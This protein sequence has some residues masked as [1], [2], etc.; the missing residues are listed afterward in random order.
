MSEPPLWLFGDQLGRHVWDTE[1]FAGREIVMVE[2][3]GAL[4]RKPFH[5]QKLHLMLSGMRHLADELGD[6]VTYLRTRT[7]REALE[8]FGRPVVVHQ[9]TSFP[10]SDMVQRFVKEGLVTEV[11]PN[12]S[13]ALSQPEFD[14]WAG[15]RETF[16]MEDFYRT[17]RRRFDVLM[18][19]DE[20]VGAKWNLDADNREPPPKGQRSL[21]VPGPWQPTEDAIDEQVRADLDEAG[22]PTVGVD[23]PR[24]FAVTHDEAQA[25]LAHFVEYRLDAFGPYEDAVMEQDWAMAHSL[26]SVPFNYGVLHPLD[27]VHAAE[28]AYRDGNASLASVEGFVRQVLGWREYVWQLYWRFG[29]E[30]TRR[31]ALGSHTSLPDW[32]TSLDADAVTAKCLGGA[33]EGVRDRGWTHHIPRLMILGNHAAQRGY[34]PAELN[35]WFATAFVDGFEW[36]MPVNVIGMS[37]HADGGAMATK[38]YSAGGAYLNRMTDHCRGCA[39]DP[40]V[41]VGEKACPFTA[42]YW[43]W[44]HRNE[45]LLAANH[46]TARAVA[47]MNRLSDLDAV[48]EQESAREEF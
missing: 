33:L 1:E 43:Q 36:V 7:Y 45:K 3:S 19:G 41:R 5:R 25:A 48:L 31:N 22:N 32:W 18:D 6:R 38:P 13:F 8:Q 28:Q 42:G 23:G 17:Q 4:G 30:Y 2:S 9:P 26:L 40:K 44:V 21:D 37:Q 46:R 29:R 39:F 35:D 15:D 14:E 20:P 10:A 11:R 24:L 34:D 27:A 16:R 47:T 12:P